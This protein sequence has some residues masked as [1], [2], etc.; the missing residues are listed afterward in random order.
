MA[1]TFVALRRLASSHRY[2]R[3]W[4]VAFGAL[5]VA[6]VTVFTR[7]QVLELP[8]PGT[9]WGPSWLRV[10]FDVV[11]Q[12][13]KLAYFGGLLTGVARY[14]GKPLPRATPLV[15]G[16]FCLS[17]AATPLLS[18]QLNSAMALQA[19]FAAVCCTM[20]AL[21]LARAPA[22]WRSFGS[23]AASIVFALLALLWVLYAISFG[24]IRFQ[25]EFLASFIWGLA[26][27]NSFIDLL[28]Q[29][30][31]AV[32]LL[33]TVFQRVEHEAEDARAER[34]ALHRRLAES[35]KLEALGVLVSGVAHELN[36]PLTSILASP[37]IC[38]SPRAPSSSSRNDAAP[39]CAACS[40][41][42][43]SAT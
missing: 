11:Y 8:P 29:T 43:A 15:A 2:L 9:L 35:E 42:R 5:G 41:S 26:H 34:A 4:S 1:G 21:Y 30:A 6:L 31:L 36:N 24:S 38:A 32:A 10:P 22:Q 27:Y 12:L 40:T 13:S 28:M 20:A 17:A 37:T 25:S 39:S 14:V 33:I 19:P 16:A 18:P 7:Y 3:D 23:R